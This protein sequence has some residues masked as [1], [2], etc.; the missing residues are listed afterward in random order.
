MDLLP[1]KNFLDAEGKLKQMP[2]KYSLQLV[3]FEMLATKFEENIDYAEPDVNRI[4]S[5][6][7]TFGDIAML[8]RGLID[9]K[10]LSRTTDGK[11]YRKI[12]KADL[13]TE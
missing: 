3:V 4:I 9:N 8:R 6:W 7:H 12:K 1:L 13:P 2:A 10:H 5:S 11:V